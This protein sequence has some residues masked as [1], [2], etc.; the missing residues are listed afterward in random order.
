MAAPAY[1][2]SLIRA[3]A[4]TAQ[5]PFEI[6]DSLVRRESG[7]NPAAVGTA[8]EYG[9]A[10]LKP[11]AAAEVG[12]NRYSPAD[13]VRGG[14]LYLRKQYDRTGN[15][16]DALRAYNAGPTAASKDLEAGRAYAAA[17]L[18]GSGLGAESGSTAT[19]LGVGDW[20]DDTFGAGAFSR[21]FNAPTPFLAIA[22]GAL[23]LLG[24][25][26]LVFSARRGVGS[27]AR[28]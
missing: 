1:I 19:G 23:I 6:L 12:V 24:I 2:E 11:E 26:A 25:V 28:V 22:S 14:A 21:Y 4:E 15:W 18:E 17:V 8:G 20:F 9:L 7:Y 16:Y 27:L 5:V 13:N 3:A 10:Q